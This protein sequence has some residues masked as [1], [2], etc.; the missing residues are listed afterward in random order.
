MSAQLKTIT[1]LFSRAD[2]FYPVHIPK[3]SVA[4]N[5]ASNPGTLKVEEYLS[6]GRH[7]VIWTWAEGWID[8]E[9]AALFGSKLCKT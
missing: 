6:N 7:R 1:Y 4:A 5:I 9:Y 2:G 8:K 3:A